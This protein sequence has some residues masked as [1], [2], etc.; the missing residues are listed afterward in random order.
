VHID[1]NGQPVTCLQNYLKPYPAGIQKKFYDTYGGEMKLSVTTAS[2]VLGN[3]NS[4]MQLY[5]LKYENPELFDKYN[6]LYIFHNTSVTSLQVK[7]MQRSQA[8]VVIPA[9]GIFQKECIT[10]GYT[11]K[12]WM[13]NF[14]LYFVPMQP[15]M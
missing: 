10:T 11:K 9:F 1:E 2:P 5:R 4:G 7:H 8:L 15:L 13:K 12:G 3:L 6:I 14:H